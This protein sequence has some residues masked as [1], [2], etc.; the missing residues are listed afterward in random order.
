M[1]KKETN[2]R[3]FLVKQIANI[4]LLFNDNVKLTEVNT[5]L[6]KLIQS[7]VQPT[8]GHKY[9]ASHALH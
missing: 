9:I 8:N 1:I 7:V 4:H 3:V 6:Q 5:T 2:K